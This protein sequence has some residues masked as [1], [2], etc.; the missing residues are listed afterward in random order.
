MQDLWR[1]TRGPGYPPVVWNGTAF[2]PCFALDDEESVYGTSAT[3]LPSRIQMSPNLVTTS[4]PSRVCCDRRLRSFALDHHERIFRHEVH[5]W[6]CRP[7][8]NVPA[9]RLCV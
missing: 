3:D 7:L 4:E 1:K 6:A 9:A 2:R 5:V 8:K